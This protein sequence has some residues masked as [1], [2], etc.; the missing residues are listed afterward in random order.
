[1]KIFNQEIGNYNPAFLIA[2]V[3]QAH[4]GSLGWAHAFVD[5]AAEA[6]ADAIK[7]QT[8]I[9]E[10]ES[11][12]DEPFR[13]R[14]T[15]QDETRY[16]YWKRMSFTR[17]QWGELSRHAREK[18]L[19]FLSSAFSLEAVEMLQELG[20]PV[21]KLGSGEYGSQY[22]FEAIAKTRLPVLLSTGMSTYDEIAIAY[23]FF[24]SRE[25]D[26]ALFQCTSQY[27]TPMTDVGVNVIEEL[28]TRYACPVG[29]SDHSGT[30]F[31]ALAALARGADMIELHVCFDK[32]M[33]GPDIPASV[34]FEEFK[35]VRNAR[36][37]FYEMSNHPVD[38]DSMSQKL[39]PIRGLFSKSIAPV[40]DLHAGDIITA[41]DLTLKKPG[42]GIPETDL[43]NVVGKRVLRAVGRDYLLKWDDIDD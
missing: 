39:K 32:K 29:L 11:T 8:H 37:A 23:N 1:M 24:Q 2:E 4:D 43:E 28:R 10:A 41:S 16:D 35:H 40:R 19:T 17:E 7:F 27:P 18:G 3:A 14:L 6:G 21:W 36:D 9:A 20:V 33:F 42:T 31:P 30:V 5:A 26:I 15:S 25:I 12:L 13:I 22:L 38:K 34:T